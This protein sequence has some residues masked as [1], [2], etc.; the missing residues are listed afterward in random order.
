MV[1]DD[2]NDE[3][4]SFVALTVG[5]K[6]S[7]YKIISKLGAGGMGEVY[8]VEDTKLKRQVAL[9][10]LP[11]YLTSDRD[12]K[13]RFTREAQAAAKLNHPNI[14]T[15]H[16]VS[17]YQGRPF[18]A[19]E[20]VEGKSLRD[21][22]KIKEAS[23]ERVI[24]LAT[25]ICDGLREAHEAGIVH[26]DIKPSN[27]ILDKK[28]RPKLLDFGL[29]AVKGTDKLTRTGSTLG[30]VGYMSP[31]QARGQKVDQRSDIFS[32]GVVLYEM[33]TGRRPFKGED[34]AATLHA[35]TD[36]TPQPLARF[37]TD[38][39]DELQQVVDRA[40]EKDAETRYQ[41]AS[42]MLAD[43]K[44]L[45]VSGLMPVTVSAQ[46]T[47][48]RKLRWAVAISVLIIAVVWGGLQLKDWL[49]PAEAQVKSLAVV[50]FDNIGAEEDAYLA[51]GLAEDLAVKLRK[52]Q[53]FHVASSADIRRLVK[54]NLLPREIAARLK[55]QYALGGSLL[56]EDTLVRVNVELIEKETGDVVWSDQIDKQFTEIFQFMDEVSRKIAQALEV[57]L[58]PVDKAAM[59]AKPTD[60][61]EA[62]DHYLKG[63][64]YYYR[65]TFRDNELAE[66]EFER[67]LQ[68]DPDYPLALAGTLRPWAEAKA[69]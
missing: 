50:D 21:L 57:R 62:Y 28:G 6:V 26:R 13:A 58:T 31:E 30:T 1:A 37:C 48:A 8:L 55:V 20:H 68:L 52:L 16:E 61:A 38:V 7:H 63:R 44:R 56:R 34:D 66:R 49:T 18:F 9:K 5:T 60:D 14:I 40:L 32:L 41:T 2:S 17:E 3:T 15:I 4:K 43:L 42:G 23:L 35:I 69:T 19:M 65:V 10:F 39:P 36:D 25:Q 12:S 22:I 54:E 33:V 24:D 67:A 29:A 47:R 46:A 27:I 45:A 53:G 59:A 11:H 64:H 51:S